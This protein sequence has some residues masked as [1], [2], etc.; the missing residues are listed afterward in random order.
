VTVRSPLSKKLRFEIFKRDGFSCSYCGAHP[1][2]V[3]LE[4]DHIVPVADGG[5]DEE[6]NLVTACF[7]CNRGK[8]ANSLSDIPTSLAQRAAE[9]QEREEQIAGYERVMREYRERL[10]A[11]AYDILRKFCDH[12]G[13]EGIPTNDF[14]SIKKFIDQLG[15]HDVVDS[16][17][18]AIAKKPYHYPSCFK[19]FCGVCWNKIRGAGQP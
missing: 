18:I 5:G 3:V 1:P 16:C 14:L 12:H 2:Q 7:S 17:E 15:F 10:D 8:A 11:S 4:V 19:Y 6:T 9:V 13:R